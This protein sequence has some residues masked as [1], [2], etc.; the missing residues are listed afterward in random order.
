MKCDGRETRGTI[1]ARRT[2]GI[3]F[4]ALCSWLMRVEVTSS[5]TLVH[6]V[7]MTGLGLV[8]L[9]SNGSRPDGAR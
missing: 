5:S 8:D 7:S 1:N 9:A 6:S 4:T 2:A 3:D